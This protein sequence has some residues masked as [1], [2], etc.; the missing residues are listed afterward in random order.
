[1]NEQHHHMPFG[2]KWQFKI[3][4][5]GTTDSAMPVT[6]IHGHEEGPHVLITAGV[7][8]GE[9]PGIAAS[10]ELAEELTPDDISGTLTVVHVVNMG[11]FWERTSEIHPVDHKNLNRV[12]PGNPEGTVTEKIAWTL[13]N[14]YI[15]TADYYID[16]HSGDIHED[17][18]CHVYYSK[19]CE[20]DVSHVSKEMAK[21]VG[22]PYMI[23]SQAEGGAYN[24]AA[25]NGVPCILIEHGCGGLCVADDVK[26]HKDDLIRLLRHLNVL[27]NDHYD[28][29][30]APE[31]K[32][33]G[34]VTYYNA[35][36]DCCWRP[37]IKSGDVVKKGD[38]V[39]Y[40]TDLFGRKMRDY[41]AE[42]DGV[43][44]CVGTSLAMKKGGV[45]AFIANVD[46]K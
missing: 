31:P 30:P 15:K 4:I 21:V 12:F 40:A 23:P 36:E 37:C 1:M 16:L 29:L 46:G 38:L 18:L 14:D 43:A 7:H 32:E 45:L 35:L 11:S 17:L 39:G 25:L 26:A 22:V 19:K 34:K 13:L 20:A 44:L 42:D 27:K 10:M 8:G 28:T 33:T 41:L 24:C 6:H 5:P 9:Y 3:Y 2:I